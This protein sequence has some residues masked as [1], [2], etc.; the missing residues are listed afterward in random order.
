MA[1]YPVCAESEV[2]VKQ[3]KT[4][5]VQDEKVLIYHLEEGFYA[6]QNSCT[7]V[8]APLGR[9]KLVNGCEVQCPLH[10]ARF[11]VRTGEVVEWACFPP[12]IQILNVVRG[13]KKLKTYPIKQENGQ[14]WVD[15]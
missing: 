14:I 8:L 3:M 4:F 2:P 12:G 9:G 13:E 10:R 11:D 5:K 15:L 1:F 7:H 6:T